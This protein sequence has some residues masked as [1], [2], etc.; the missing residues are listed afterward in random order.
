MCWYKKCWEKENSSK[1]PKTKFMHFDLPLFLGHA[2]L[3]EDKIISFRDPWETKCPGT[4]VDKHHGKNEE[5]NKCENI[6]KLFM[7]MEI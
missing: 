4:K 6:Y 3:F 5:N 7:K 2:M 1:K